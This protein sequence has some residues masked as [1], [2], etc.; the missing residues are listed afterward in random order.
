MVSEVEQQLETRDVILEEL[1]NHL[2]RAQEKMKTTADKRHRDV[3]FEVGEKVF[4]KLHPYHQQS[5]AKRR[6]EK[7]APRFYGPYE[8]LA[9]VGVVAYKLS[10]PDGARIHP[11]FHVSQLRQAIS[12]TQVSYQF[13]PQ[14]NT[15]QILEVEPKQVLG[16]RPS[17]E[18]PPGTLEVLIQSR[19]LLVFEASWEPFSTIQD[20]YPACHLEDKVKHWATSN[21]KLP[22]RFTYA[23]RHK[24]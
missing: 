11:V 18:G 19:D 9:H 5:L 23:R 17:T 2:S 3:Q 16:V 24:S 22:I 21:V 15:E 13:P 8:V 4:L 10:L 20:Q 12:A 1:K 14:F 6:N 7:L